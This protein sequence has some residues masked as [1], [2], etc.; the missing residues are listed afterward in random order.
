[1]PLLAFNRKDT[2]WRIDWQLAPK[3]A[4]NPADLVSHPPKTLA[5]WRYRGRRR[6]NPATPARIG[7]QLT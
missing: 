3:A 6:G 4:D 1:M 5:V 2:G 7:R